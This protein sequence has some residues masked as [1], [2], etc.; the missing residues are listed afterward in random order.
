MDGQTVRVLDLR[1]HRLITIP[2]RELAPGMVRA[3]VEGIEGDVWVDASQVRQGS[4]RQPPFGEDVLRVVRH[5]RDALLDVVPMTVEE[6]EDGFRRD[7]NPADEIAFW[8]T[9]AEAYTHFT[10]GR[11]LSAEQKLDLVEVIY[12]CLNNGTDYVLL[13]TSPATLS[14]EGVK[15]IAKYVD[16]MAG[17]DEG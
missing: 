13:T 10:A 15:E 16:R 11:P 6:W 7:D 12:A 5:I 8:R 2:A 4:V 9:V 1:T 3:R 17:Q 14:R